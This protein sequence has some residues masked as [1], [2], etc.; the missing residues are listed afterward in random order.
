MIEVQ[1]LAK[2]Y[3]PR[4]AIQ[5]LTFQ[6]NQGE[7]VGFLGPNGAG[8]TT[9]MNILCC[10]LPASS[11][12]ARVC[13][14]DI[15]EQS[16]EIR[17]RIGYLPET[18][19]LY[20]DMVVS[21]YLAFAAGLRGVPKKQIPSAVDRVLGQCHIRDVQDRII[22]RLSKGY[23]QRIGLAQAMIHDPEI[24]ILDEPTIGLDPIQIIEIRKLIQELGKSHTILLSSHIL[25]EVT[26][27]CQRV[28]IIHEGRIAAMDTLDGLNAS[29][30]HSNRLELKVR[31]ADTGI[32]PKLEALDK[33]SAVHPD[34][35]N[36]FI[37]DI[38]SNQPAQDDVA[39]MVLE[40]G[41]GLEELK[42]VSMTLEDI[43]LKLTTEEKLDTPS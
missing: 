16:Y 1:N 11:G 26:Q 3:G 21:K 37:I 20:Q 34:G 30:R 35:V 10:I 41:W 18:P 25:P 36:R 12:T 4:S 39:R 28:I 43:F 6:V 42:P 8:K 22:G 29:L 7:V 24:L 19:P 15:F 40:Q 17:K 13:G 14:F 38:E 31:N 33:V 32:T 2:S 27:I 9:T 23:Q 5:G